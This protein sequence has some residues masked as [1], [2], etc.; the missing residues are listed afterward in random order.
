MIIIE[1]VAKRKGISR[2]VQKE[3][4]TPEGVPLSFY[5]RMVAKRKGVSRLG[6]APAHL[7]VSPH[8]STL[9]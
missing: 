1:M 5:H 7:K 2:L 8:R 3:T 6:T 4:S 9:K